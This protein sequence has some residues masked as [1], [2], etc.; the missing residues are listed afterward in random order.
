MFIFTDK[1][2]YINL[3]TMFTDNLKRIC[4]AGMIMLCT[5][6]MLH[7]QDTLRLTLPETEKQFLEKNL[8]LLAERF[9]IDAA[10]AQVMQAKLYNNPNFSYTANIYNPDQKKW[11]DVS[12]KTGEYGIS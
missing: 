1:F 4:F 8:Q 2:P 9:N 5:H 7:A 11:V 3:L 12:S 10:K 6:S